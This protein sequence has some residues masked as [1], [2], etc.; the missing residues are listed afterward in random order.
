MDT[1][2]VCF[3]HATTTTTSGDAP[4]RMEKTS[5]SQTCCSFLAKVFEHLCVRLAASKPTWDATPCLEPSF[6]VDL[7]RQFL[8]CN[9]HAALVEPAVHR[10]CQ[11]SS[12]RFYFA[13]DIS[14]F[15][16]QFEFESVVII[17]H[18]WRHLIIDLPQFSSEDA[19][20]TASTTAVA[21]GIAIASTTASTIAVAVTFGCACARTLTAAATVS[22]SASD[23]PNSALTFSSSGPPPVL[24]WAR[25]L[26]HIV[27]KTHNW[28]F[29]FPP[30]SAP[31]TLEVL[32]NIGDAN[33]L[34]R[35]KIAQLV[36]EAVYL[37]IPPGQEL[38]R[39]RDVCKQASSIILDIE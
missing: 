4:F 18:V 38:G 20:T 13:N 30:S 16:M 17:V 3:A 34:R 7:V 11:P 35:L 19:S 21:V 24:T 8:G 10:R 27:D 5:T 14:V 25:S 31:Q 39:Q 37:D 15:I 29:A 26:Q 1:L 33:D 6:H 12:D 36:V 28:I 2:A 23:R 22:K 9:L 32:C